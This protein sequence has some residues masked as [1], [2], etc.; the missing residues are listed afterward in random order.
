[1]AKKI[2]S[3]GEATLDSFMFLHD[4]NVRCTID[5]AKCEFCMNY[6]DKI[7]ADQLVFSVGG[8][9][10]NTAVTFARF[11]FTSQ[12]YSAIGSDWVAEKIEKDLTAE[13]I[14][15]A[16]FQRQSGPTSYATAL[17]FQEERNLVIYHV[18][19]DY[20]LPDFEIVDW[21]YL[22]SMGKSF[23][24]AY[25][26]ALSFAK[27]NKIG[28][29]FNPG[30]YQLKAGV[31]KIKH[32]IAQTELLFVNKEEA[33]ILTELPTSA[34]I[35]KLSE[36]LYDL[37][38][39]IVNITDGPEGAYCFDGSQLL[40]CPIFPIK[41]VERTGAGDSYAS[42]FTA[43]YINGKSLDEA[44]RW[45]MANSAG[46][47]AEIGPQKGILTPESLEEVLS[48]NSEIQPQRSKL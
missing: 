22:T 10:A 43:A 35:R 25:D 30:S 6:A 19:R 32:I 20:V 41:V 28:I 14:D 26:K 5:K 23:I 24:G 38:A 3:I 29:S 16:Y 34:N 21:V 45:G 7:L 39:K 40:F 36:A 8:N 18:P 44:M 47:I 1:M 15:C 11:G 27:Q 17:V 13:G 2:L 37:G 4:A 33:R 46:V 9:A 12:L 42:A 31:D 48:K